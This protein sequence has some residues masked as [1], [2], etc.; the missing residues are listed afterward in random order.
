MKFTLA[1][2]LVALPAI[3]TASPVQ[4][5]QDSSLCA[6]GGLTSL[7]ACCTGELA[8]HLAAT[9]LGGTF[10]ALC[11]PIDTVCGVAATLVNLCCPADDGTAQ[12]SPTC[13]VSGFNGTTGGLG[14]VIGGLGGII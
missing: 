5:R 6:S 9:P 4:T 13:I 8:G 2:L 1:A 14:G 10:A 7:D 3:V 11:S 12:L